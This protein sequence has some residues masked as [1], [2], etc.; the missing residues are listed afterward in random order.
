MEDPICRRFVLPLAGSEKIPH[1]R[2]RTGAADTLRSL[3]RRSQAEDLVSAAGQQCDQLRAEE[4]IRCRD[5][6]GRFCAGHVVSV[7][8]ERSRYYPQRS[9]G[10]RTSSVR[11]LVAVR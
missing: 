7:K 8:G 5:E 9:Y 6:C 10:A 4:S 3:D 11:S 1:D 2:D